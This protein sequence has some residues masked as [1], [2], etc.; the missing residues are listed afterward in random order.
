MGERSRS[1]QEPISNSDSVALSID[2]VSTRGLDRTVS[3][4]FLPLRTGVD[5]SQTQF[6]VAR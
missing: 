4:R 6:R 2:A 5:N 1:S 3:S